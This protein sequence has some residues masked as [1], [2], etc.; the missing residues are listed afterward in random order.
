MFLGVHALN[1][2]NKWRGYQLCFLL[3]FEIKFSRPQKKVPVISL[4]LMDRT[5]KC[6]NIQDRSCKTAAL[7]RRGE[8]KENPKKK[9]QK[10]GEERWPF[11]TLSATQNPP[12][13][14]ER[15]ASLAL[16]DPMATDLVEAPS[17][18]SQSPSHYR[19]FY[20][21]FNFWLVFSPFFITQASKPAFAQLN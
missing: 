17:P 6:E 14:R 18:T 13:E 21:C 19:F 16:S 3:N 15:E 8:E 11:F 2:Q 7:H 12:E 1:C 4:N 5:A 9:N 10:E 20:N